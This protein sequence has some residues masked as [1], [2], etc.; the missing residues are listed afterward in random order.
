M[1]D[2]V[3]SGEVSDLVLARGVPA[4]VDVDHQPEGDGNRLASTT[5]SAH[6]RCESVQ[7][8]IR[9]FAPAPREAAVNPWSPNVPMI[10]A[11]PVGCLIWAH[12]QPTVAG[13]C[14][15]V[16][17]GLELSVLRHLG[18]TLTCSPCPS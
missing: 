6:E 8:R 13:A 12:E 10:P 11:F 14:Q 18:Q 15:A 16:P 9:G 3:D 17:C 2:A 7:A 1:K 4:A 5:P